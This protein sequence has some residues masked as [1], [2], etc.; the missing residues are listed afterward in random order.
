MRNPFSTKA[1][2]AYIAKEVYGLNLKKDFFELS[3][4]ELH[5]LEDFKKV[6][7]YK[8]DNEL[9]RSRLRQFFYHLQ[10]GAKELPF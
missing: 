3:G 9:G 8:G 6:C 5:T 10:S 7:N 1:H 4:T 2:R